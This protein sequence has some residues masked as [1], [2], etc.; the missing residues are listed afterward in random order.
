MEERITQSIDAHISAF[1]AESG[2]S[3]A[4]LANYLEITPNT[5]RNKREGRNDWRL[6]EVVKLSELF[7]KSLTDLAY[8]GLN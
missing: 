5:L 7:C 4:W 1:L 8:H 2:K 3:V 6:S